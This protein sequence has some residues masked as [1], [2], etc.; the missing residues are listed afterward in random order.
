M[1]YRDRL[2]LLL[3]FCFCSFGL[4][5]T[6]LLQSSQLSQ[7]KHNKHQNYPI[8]NTEKFHSSIVG[9]N[10]RNTDRNLDRKS[11][12]NNI[13]SYRDQDMSLRLS[14]IATADTGE[15]SMQNKNKFEKLVISCMISIS[16]MSI[17]ISVM[18]LSSVY[19]ALTADATFYS[20]QTSSSFLAQMNSVAPLFTFFGKFLLGK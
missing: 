20:K 8:H 7:S 17:I 19:I 14:S 5:V 2:I 4:S 10:N 9:R 13:N 6:A 3:L 1:L 12:T 11:N 16:Y 18:S 15:N